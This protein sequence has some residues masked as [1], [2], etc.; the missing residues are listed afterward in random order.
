MNKKILI[1]NGSPRLKGN[2]STLCDAFITGAESVGHTVTRID[3]QKLEIHGCLGCMKGGKDPSS[4]CVQK[5]GMEKIYQPYVD[6]DIVVLASPMYYWAFSGQLK[7]AF[8]RLFAVAECNPSYANPRK[9]CILIMAAEGDTPENWK[10]VLDY[11]K[12][13]CGF[14]EWNDLGQILAGGVLEA[15]AV[16]GKQ[17][18]EDAKKFGASLYS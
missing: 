14:L 9:D 10:P 2:T 11:Y 7:T 1:L 5:D 16:V 18:V 17:I 6:A 4:P 15:G 8:D 12:A 13:L 3:L